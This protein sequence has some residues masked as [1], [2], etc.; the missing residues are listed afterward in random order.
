MGAGKALVLSAVLTA[1][2]YLGLS[3]PGWVAG[4]L[5]LLGFLGLG[6]W[7]ITRIAFKTL[8]RDIK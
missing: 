3:F 7:P 4:A 1:G 5:G 8:P 2:V 6:G